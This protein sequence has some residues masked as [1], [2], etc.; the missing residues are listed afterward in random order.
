MQRWQGKLRRERAMK[1]FTWVEPDA[2]E[3]DDALEDWVRLATR[4]VE[5]MPLEEAKAKPAPR[6]APARKAA[7]KKAATAPKTL[8]RR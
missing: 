6:R 2:I 4:W 1:G 8:A 7:A 3:D 5:Q